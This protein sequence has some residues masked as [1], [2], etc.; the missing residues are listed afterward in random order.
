MTMQTRR[1]FLRQS[2]IVTAGAALVGCRTAGP[3]RLSP[4]EKLNI[5]VIGTA[6]RASQNIRGIES[7][8]IVALC[9]ID[10]N[11]LGAALKRFPD[12]KGYNDFRKMLER[13]DIDAVVVS[14]ADHVHAVATAAALRSGR[15]VYCEKPLTHTVA[16]AR[17]IAKLAARHKN[18]ATQMGIQIHATENYRRVVELVQAGVIGPIRECH[19]WC[20]KSLP[21]PARPNDMPLIPEGLHWDLWLGPA[22]A[23]PYNPVYLPKTWRRWWDF[24]SG[25]LGDMACH[26][27]D[28]PFWALELRHPFSIESEGPAVNTETV[29]LWM[30]V[31]YQF[32]ARGHLPAVN[33]TWYDG[34]RRPDQVNESMVEKWP[35]GVLFV[36]SK[37]MLIADYG[38]HRLLPEADFKDFVAPARTIPPS[39]GHHKEWITACKTGSRTSCSF[40]YGAALSESVL[41]GN[42]AYRT[43]QK[44]LWEA[45][46]GRVTNTGQA[47]NFLQTDYRR[48]W[49]L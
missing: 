32:A 31:R 19:V 40:A 5:A 44:I 28:L 48:G 2:A 36:G 41:L 26:Y 34:G 49:T 8:N 22:P 29:P 14:T 33:L 17:T 1:E 24:G 25:I 21:G 16:E 12:A 9:D 45:S 15:H 4:N 11:F 27:I 3:R 46:R 35:N 42:V 37:G 47:A 43:G 23:R 39:V 18:L 10:E 20:E 13:S 30:I 6:N 7:E 38:K